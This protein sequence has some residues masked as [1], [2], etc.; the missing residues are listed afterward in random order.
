MWL[1]ILRG[2]AYNSMLCLVILRGVAYNLM[3]VACDFK[4]C[5]LHFDGCGL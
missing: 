3:G 5:D 2:V 1:V 4:G